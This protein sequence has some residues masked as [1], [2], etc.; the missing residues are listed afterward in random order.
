[1]AAY[2]LHAVDH[3]HISAFGGG[4]GLVVNGL[5]DETPQHF[6]VDGFA[7]A[8]VRFLVEPTHANLAEISGMAARKQEKD[9]INRRRAKLHTQKFTHNR[10]KRV[11]WWC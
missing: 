6:H 11:L 5:A 3:R 2:L 8:G 9:N 1:V 10:S 7:V 4:L